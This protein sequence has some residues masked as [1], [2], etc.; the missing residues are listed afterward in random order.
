MPTGTSEVELNQGS[1]IKAETT[2]L[3]WWMGGLLEHMGRNVSS[4]KLSCSWRL[5]W[6]GQNI[7]HKYIQTHLLSFSSHFRLATF[8]VHRVHGRHKLDICCYWEGTE[9]QS[10][11]CVPSD[12]WK[13]PN[14]Q[15]VDCFP[16]TSFSSCVSRIVH[17]TSLMFSLHYLKNNL[18]LSIHVLFIE[19]LTLFFI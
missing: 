9:L 8:C 3:G 2:T 11:V 5:G 18:Y 13:L 16:P 12:G 15:D 14:E 6:A 17:H 10:Q 1:K 4:G 7:L 19:V